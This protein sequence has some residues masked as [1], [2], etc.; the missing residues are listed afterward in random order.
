MVLRLGLVGM[1]GAKEIRHHASKNPHKD[2]S[3]MECVC[4][5]IPFGIPRFQYVEQKCLA[6]IVLCCSIGVSWHCI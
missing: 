4:V 2:R 3:T 5:L 6:A 1:V